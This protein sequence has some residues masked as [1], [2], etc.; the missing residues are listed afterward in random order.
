MLAFEFVIYSLE[1]LIVQ[2]PSLT[3]KKGYM[4]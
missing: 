4:W 2:A 3:A 1:F